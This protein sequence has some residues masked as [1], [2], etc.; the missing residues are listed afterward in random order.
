M[1]QSRQGQG[2]SSPVADDRVMGKGHVSRVLRTPTGIQGSCRARLGGPPSGQKR[3]SIEAE[4][5]CRGVP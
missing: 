3:T 4:E 1:I 5:T 2:A